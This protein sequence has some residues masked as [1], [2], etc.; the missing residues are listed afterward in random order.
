MVVWVIGEFLFRMLVAF[1]NLPEGSG[2][3]S[4]DSMDLL[5]SSLFSS[6]TFPS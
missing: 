5:A 4:P 2:F 3:M 1:L 6:R